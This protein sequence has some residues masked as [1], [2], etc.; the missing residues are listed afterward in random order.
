MSSS[1]SVP[2]YRAPASVVRRSVTWKKSKPHVLMCSD[3]GVAAQELNRC[4]HQMNRRTNVLLKDLF[5]WVQIFLKYK[6]SWLY[7]LKL[8]LVIHCG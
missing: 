2:G 4:Q 1:L 6:K 8:I 7:F 3:V 5:I